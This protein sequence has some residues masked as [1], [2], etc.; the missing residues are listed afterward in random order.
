MCFF[1]LIINCF[2]IIRVL[3]DM[4]VIIIDRLKIIYLALVGHINMQSN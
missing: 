4:N 2:A 1:V 3:L